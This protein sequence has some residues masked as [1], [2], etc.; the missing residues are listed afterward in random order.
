MILITVESDS[1]FLWALLLHCNYN[2]LQKLCPRFVLQYNM[3]KIWF[4]PG[5]GVLTL[6]ARNWCPELDHYK[7]KQTTTFL[8]WGGIGFENYFAVWH[9][10]SERLFYVQN[11][12]IALL[13]CCNSYNSV[14]VVVIFAFSSISSKFFFK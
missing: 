7:Q 8:V 14:V 5:F 3:A 12:L 2:I 10:F 1:E 4:S 9:V 6:G 13:F 11:K